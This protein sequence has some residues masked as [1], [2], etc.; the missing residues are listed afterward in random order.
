[1]NSSIST[2]KVAVQDTHEYKVEQAAPRLEAYDWPFVSIIVTVTDEGETIEAC[3]KS[4]LDLDYDS[5]EILIIDTGS[6]DNTRETVKKI[7]RDNQRMRLL[8]TSGNASGGRN[9]GIRESKGN[10]LAFTDGDCVVTKG[11][12]RTLVRSLI[13]DGR[14]TAGVGGPNVPLFT[15]ETR[16]STAANA[17]LNTFFGSGG[18]AQV[19]NTNNPYV[20]AL[21]TANAAF[22]TESIRKIG[23]FDLRLD[24]CEDA[25]LSSRLS[26]AG[27][28]LRF[29]KAAV[30][31][32]RRDYQSLWKFGRHMFKYGNWRGKAIIIKPRTNLSYTS[33]TILG[34][35]ATIAFLLSLSLFGSKTAGLAM[36]FST[37]LYL[38]ILVAQAMIVSRGVL[39][40]FLA[41]VPA[42]LIL[43]ASY[44]TGL[45]SG[46]FLAIL[47]PRR[48]R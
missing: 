26:K 10:V 28:R 9:L 17:T 42:F 43:H 36:I 34:V 22:W 3:L 24:M 21:S 25:D 23:S 44:A 4:L 48:N 31:Y 46:I 19:K 11:W 16:W 40:I 35:L 38:L 41:V 15:V 14:S 5:Y 30:V 2:T 32:H 27:S 33:L 47:R 8:T 39:G 7:E 20:R 18:S 12:L 45:I 29:E 37:A 6:T 1:L 13:N